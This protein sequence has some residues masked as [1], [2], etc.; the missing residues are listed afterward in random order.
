MPLDTCQLE[1]TNLI[2]S[3]SDKADLCALRLSCK[4]LYAKLQTTFAAFFQR[5][6]VFSTRENLDRLEA[7]AHTPLFRLY[8]KEV[9]LVPDVFRSL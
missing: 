2:I 5:L 1:L 3:F 6:T 9:A 7:V 8:L 4:A